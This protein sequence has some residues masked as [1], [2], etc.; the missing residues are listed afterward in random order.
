VRGHNKKALW[1]RRFYRLL[2]CPIQQL[3]VPHPASGFG[4]KSLTCGVH[5]RADAALPS[6]GVRQFRHGLQLAAGTVSHATQEFQQLPKCDLRSFVTSLA[7]MK[8]LFPIT[9]FIFGSLSP[10][11]GSSDPVAQ[12]Q[13]GAAMQQADIFHDRASPFQLNIEFIAQVNIPTRG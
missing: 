3:D 12:Q 11:F 9:V 4:R 2:H 10:L 13:L 6:G 5:R 1:R 8:K 7:T